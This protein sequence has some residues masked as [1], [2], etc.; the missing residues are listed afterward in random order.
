MVEPHELSRRDLL[1]LAGAA[2]AMAAAGARVVEAQTPKRG[3]V[4]RLAGFDPPHFDPQQ[5]PHWWTAITLSFTHNSLVKTKAGPGVS[6]GTLPIE[7]SLA[8]S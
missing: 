6:P 2:G 5:T 1:K 7:G 3:G 4:F 8:E